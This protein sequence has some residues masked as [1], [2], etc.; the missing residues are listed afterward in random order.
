MAKNK[1]ITVFELYK[2]CIKLINEGHANKYVFLIDDD[3]WNG[4]HACW[5]LINPKIEYD[6]YREMC[7]DNYCNPDECVLL[8]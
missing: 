8:G 6:D 7:R 5:Y 3:E 4:I 2:N 1:P